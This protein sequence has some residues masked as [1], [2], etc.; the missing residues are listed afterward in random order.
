MN[1]VS[2]LQ[3]LLN[4]VLCKKTC[5]KFFRYN[6]LPTKELCETWDKID[7]FHL[8]QRPMTLK[9]CGHL[10]FSC[11]ISEK[12]TYRPTL[13]ISCFFFLF[14]FA[15]FVFFMHTTPL[16]LCISVPQITSKLTLVGTEKYPC[17]LVLSVITGAPILT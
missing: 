11:Y 4:L 15:I 1:I 16:H 13:L 12:V 9:Q 17:T 2:Q 7:L 6:I 14:F 3:N 10:P 5:W 8:P